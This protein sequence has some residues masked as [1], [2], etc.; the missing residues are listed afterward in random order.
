MAHKLQM[1]LK[2]NE[3]KKSKTTYK[4]IFLYGLRLKVG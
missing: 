2:I 4:G 3:K 1:K